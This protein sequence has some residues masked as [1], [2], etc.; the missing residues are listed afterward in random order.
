M[1]LGSLPHYVFPEHLLCAPTLEQT[2]G[3]MTVKTTG[4]HP[5]VTSVLLGRRAERVMAAPHSSPF[6]GP[7]PAPD[8]SAR[9]PRIFRKEKPREPRE[10]SRIPARPL[11]R[12]HHPRPRVSGTPV[13]PC[14]SQ[15]RTLRTASL[16]ASVSLFQNLPRQPQRSPEQASLSRWKSQLGSWRLGKGR[17]LK[18]N[19]SPQ[20]GS[21]R[22]APGERKLTPGAPGR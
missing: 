16:K 21:S 17:A 9:S 5:P 15:M 11:S 14:L 13:Q 12:R 6:S 1:G 22:R 20:P 8:R 3:V 10:G 7:G 18:I 4:P 19:H 2:R